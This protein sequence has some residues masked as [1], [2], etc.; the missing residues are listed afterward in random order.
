MTIGAE[1]GALGSLAANGAAPPQSPGEQMEYLF[2]QQLLHALSEAGG[3]EGQEGQDG[4]NYLSL[5]GEPLAK[6]IARS[7]GLGIGQQIMKEGAR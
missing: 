7:G 6:E 3:E 1:T 4:A 2:A 5:L